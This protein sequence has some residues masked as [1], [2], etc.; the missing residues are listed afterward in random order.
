MGCHLSR[1]LQLDPNTGAYPDPSRLYESF[2]FADTF[3]RNQ[4]IHDDIVNDQMPHAEPTMRSFWTPQGSISPRSALIG[5]MQ[6]SNPS[7][8]GVSSSLPSSAICQSS[9]DCGK[10]D[11]GR[12]CAP[13]VTADYGS[14]GQHTSNVCLD[15]CS[16]SQ[17]RE[18]P[19]FS[20][21]VPDASQAPPADGICQHC[22][23][24][25]QPACT[26]FRSLPD[27]SLLQS[28]GGCFQGRR[29]SVY[30]PCTAECLPEAPACANGFCDTTT[31][32]CFVPKIPVFARVR[33]TP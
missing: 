3:L 26:A 17:G 21:C 20:Q 33:A 9:L 11:A 29:V 15:A 14:L 23:L 10:N 32:R 25:G 4:T 16:L 24:V 6:A 28:T 22:G 19:F 1:E 2:G 5:M 27:P 31:L 13:A 12:V 7:F 18:C 30:G 8:S